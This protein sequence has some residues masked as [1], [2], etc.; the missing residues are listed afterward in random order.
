MR[1]RGADLS[2]SKLIDIRGL[3]FCGVKNGVCN[4]LEIMVGKWKQHR[5]EQ[6]RRIKS[7]DDINRLAG[8]R[9]VAIARDDQPAGVQPASRA[10][11][12]LRDCVG[13]AGR[14]LMEGVG[15]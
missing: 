13:S 15:G 6:T 10:S 4:T 7:A 9:A 5:S 8:V 12:A 14:A 2:A 1:M 3:P 11:D